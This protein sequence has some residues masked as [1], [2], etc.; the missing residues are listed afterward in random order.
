GYVYY[1]SGISAAALVPGVSKAVSGIP[2]ATSANIVV[3]KAG[4]EVWRYDPPAGQDVSNFR[5]QTYHG[6]RVLTWW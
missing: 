3:D 6:K 2:A 1:S 5:T 4:R